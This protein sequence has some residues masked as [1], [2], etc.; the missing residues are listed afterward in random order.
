L[1]GTGASGNCL[2]KLNA[3]TRDGSVLQAQDVQAM[4]QTGIQQVSVTNIELLSSR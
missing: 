2:S 1:N 3:P 4:R